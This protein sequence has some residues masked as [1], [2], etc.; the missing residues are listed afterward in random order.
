MGKEE[1]EE[2]EEEKY[3]EKDGEKDQG[4]G[5]LIISSSLDVA[6][7]SISLQARS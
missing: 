7:R 5:F 2:E 3:G 6:G 4:P 1:D